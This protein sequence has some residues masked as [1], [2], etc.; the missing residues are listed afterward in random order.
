MVSE[1][2]DAAN[3]FVIECMHTSIAYYCNIS[4][5]EK[6]NTGI[7]FKSLADGEW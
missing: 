7:Q 2:N 6:Q 1:R 3:E 4:V 5:K